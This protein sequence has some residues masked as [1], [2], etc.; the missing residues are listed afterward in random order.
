MNPRSVAPLRQEQATAPGF[1][2]SSLGPVSDCCNSRRLRVYVLDEDP[3][4]ALAGIAAF[5]ERSGTE[6]VV[7]RCEQRGRE[8]TT[9]EAF[10]ALCIGADYFHGQDAVS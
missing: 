7:R 1:V 8:V 5:A 2:T 10:E 6:G 4:L 9:L 3:L